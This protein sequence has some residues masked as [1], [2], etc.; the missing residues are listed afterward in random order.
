MVGKM[1]D[2]D[3]MQTYLSVLLALLSSCSRSALMRCGLVLG[4]GES[5]EDLGVEECL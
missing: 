2:T 3:W 4:H 5:F 1:R